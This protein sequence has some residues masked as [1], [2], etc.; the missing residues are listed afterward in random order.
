MAPDAAE[1]DL[2]IT[3]CAYAPGEKMTRPAE[4]AELLATYHRAATDALHKQSLIQTVARKGPKAIAAAVD[5]AAKA[6]KRKNAFAA[7]LKQLGVDVQD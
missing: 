1:I 3:A 4:H 5:T 6:A 2:T 7:K